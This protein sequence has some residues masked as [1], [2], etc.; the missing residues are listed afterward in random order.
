MSRLGEL[1]ARTYS[2]LCGHHPRLFPWHFQWHCMR[3]LE[4]DLRT[5][6][7]PLGGEVLDLGCGQTPYRTYFGLKVASYVGA[8]VVPGPTVQVV[9]RD[10][11]PL[12]F[13]DSSF[14]TILCTQVLEHVGEFGNLLAEVKRVL[15]PEGTLLISVP[16]LFH[17]HGEPYDF[18]RFT[19][20]GLVNIL[21]NG[22][23]VQV[24]KT[25]GGVGSHLAITLLAWVE[26]QSNCALLTRLVKGFLLPAWMA[27]CLLVNLSGLVLDTLDSTGC[28]V[29]N[30]LAIAHRKSQSY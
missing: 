19:P 16:F 28:F 10:G 2:T 21:E 22:F 1:Y 13:A 25:Q 6:L 4:R 24:L 8:D 27:F 30:T 29:H 5:A 9:I 14:D 12:P 7:A 15:R 11:E 20:R 18:R 17:Q 26:V 3:E 23:E